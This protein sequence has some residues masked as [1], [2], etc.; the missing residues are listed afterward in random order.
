MMSEPT[1]LLDDPAI[2]EGLR[3]DLVQAQSVVLQGL[4]LSAG[5]AGL[6]AAIAA[7]TT[8]AGAAGA[9]A[10]KIAVLGIAGA[11][12][13]GALVWF[14]LRAPETEPP[15]VAAP[16]VEEQ[17]ELAS[18]GPRLTAPQPELAVL[19]GSDEPEF[20]PVAPVPTPVVV[21]SDREPE[22]AR[23]SRKRP[24]KDDKQADYL[25][26]ARLISKARA[27]LKTDASGALKLLTQARS[28]FPRGLLREEREALT[29]LSLAKLGRSTQAKASAKRFL[30]KHDESPYAAAIRQ[31]LGASEPG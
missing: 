3:A 27:A 14:A 13:A 5:A 31:V 20:V 25:R 28:E 10:G 15:L 26:E 2:A 12:A 4:D 24:R 30:E 16:I 1:R 17:A 19:P 22:V 29:I 21:Q 7:E 6:S 11:V 8:A 9:G 23:S 18:P